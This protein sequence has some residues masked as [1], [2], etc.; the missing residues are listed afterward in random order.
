MKPQFTEV[1]LGI[2]RADSPD[3]V[4]SQFAG[5]SADDWPILVDEAVHFRLAYQLQS[6]LAAQDPQ[7]GTSFP[8][9][10]RN[11]LADSVR[12]TLLHNLGQQHLLHKM[13]AACRDADVPVL[14]LKGLWL[15]EV[16]YADL[17]ARNSGDIDLM[18]H[19]EDMPKFLQIAR[20]LDLSIPV[21]EEDM[22]EFMLGQNEMTLYAGNKASFDVHW[23]FTRPGE[24][25]PVDEARLWQRAEYFNVAGLPCL[26]LCLEDHLL[27]LCFHTALH[28]CF[29]YVG[30]R[31]L[32]DV[33][34]LIANSPRPI[35]WDYFVDSAQTLGWQRGAGLTLELVRVH[36]GVSLPL[37]VMQALNPAGIPAAVVDAALQAVFSG[38]EIH[39]SLTPNIVRMFDE[40]GWRRKLSVL[41]SRVFPSFEAI[42][43]MFRQHHPHASIYSLYVKHWRRLFKDHAAKS[44]G[45]L[46]G[47]R[48]QHAELY[49]AKVLRHWMEL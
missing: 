12:A 14:L 6:F 3:L 25:K 39:D 30:P 27:Y 24:E 40:S 45:L 36:L 8:T 28:H 1:L 38:Q 13:L 20:T 35:D 42:E 18:L 2:L 11:R 15:T 41:V 5:L 22:S 34:K 44:V 29:L 31:A 49:R 21:S 33:V 17:K 46:L 4:L 10:C 47:E 37:D 19:P 43:S 23:S 26:S 7:L 48:Q 32:L 16:I 9:L